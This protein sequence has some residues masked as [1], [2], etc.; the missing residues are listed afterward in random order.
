MSATV[1]LVVFVGGLVVELG[2][3]VVL[4]RTVTRPWEKQHSGRAP[5]AAASSGDAPHAGARHRVDGRPVDHRAGVHRARGTDDSLLPE[6]AARASSI[7]GRTAGR[8]AGGPE[9]G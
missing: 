7:A 8:H 3:I 2:A 6:N 1:V 4:G 5:F 9:R